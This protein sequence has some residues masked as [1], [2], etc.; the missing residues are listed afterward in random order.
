MDH[1]RKSNHIMDMERGK[2]ISQE[3][4]TLKQWI[5]KVTEIRRR[6]NDRINR[7]EEAYTLSHTWESL[8]GRLG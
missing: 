3:A 1:C 6:A 4:N 5:K 7:D 8:R 2:V